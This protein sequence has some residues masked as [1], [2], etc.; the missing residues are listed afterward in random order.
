MKAHPH[1]LVLN[2]GSSS[3]RFSF[4]TLSGKKVLQKNIDRIGVRGGTYATHTAAFAA[5][6][7]A[8]ATQ[9][10]PRADI[11]AVGH[12]IVHGGERFR[13]PIRITANVK[14]GIAR[15]A[16]LAPLHNPVALQ[17]IRRSQ[18][19]FPHA[20]Q[21]AVFDTGLYADMP[22]AAQTYALP[23][24]ISRRYGIRRYGFHGLSHEHAL[25][26]AVA[27][28]GKPAQKLNL[29]SLHFGSGAS[30]TAFQ[31]GK[32]IATSMGFTPMEGLLMTTRVGD[33]DPG[34]IL[35]LL[36]QGIS[37]E[38]LTHILNNESGWYGLTGKKDFRDVL[39]AAGF[40]REKGVKPYRVTA[41]QR[42]NAQL[43]LNIFLRHS[44]FYLGGY[45]ALLGT[46]DAI[47][48]TGEIGAANG[49][50]R[51]EIMRSLPQFRGV[52]ILNVQADE[53]A[54]IAQYARRFLSS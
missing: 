28:T 53:A 24:N 42:K 34:I 50:I 41:T 27:R 46:V 45:A 23:R 5:V 39:Y 8:L 40:S 11:V 3:L 48:F 6:R 13:R 33:I 9:R 38:K 17:S 7:L 31:R 51:K 44:R 36:K 2:A 49:K 21:Y 37:P 4:F 18:G 47:V 30:I 14:K 20:M 32:A 10:I 12:R 35:Y 16:S 19:M 1:I 25:H 26:I 43:A 22:E 15:A 29:I 54:V 52:R